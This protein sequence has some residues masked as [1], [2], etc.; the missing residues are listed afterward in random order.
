MLHVGIIRFII[1]TQSDIVPIL[2]I[3]YYYL[4]MPETLA[5]R[6]MG[7]T[8]MMTEKGQTFGLNQM[9]IVKEETSGMGN[10]QKNVLCT[11]PTNA[12]SPMKLSARCY[13]DK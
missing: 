13:R 6:D 1:L 12:Q 11:D 4:K 5:L 10:T 2:I 9:L 8:Q 7:G 3:M